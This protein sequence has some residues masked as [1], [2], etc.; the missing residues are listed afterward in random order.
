M[1]GVGM[2]TSEEIKFHPDT[3]ALLTKSTWV[4]QIDRQIDIQIERQLDMMGVGM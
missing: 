4:I 3:G 1:M 2:W